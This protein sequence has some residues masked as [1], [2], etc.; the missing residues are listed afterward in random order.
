MTSSTPIIR[1][2]SGISEVVKDIIA[3]SEIL[4]K[5][6]DVKY[7]DML[8]QVSF[9]GR[10]EWEDVEVKIYIISEGCMWLVIKIGN[11]TLSGTYFN[12]RMIAESIEELFKVGI[13][14]LKISMAIERMP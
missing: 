9:L 12:A 8:S 7:Y 1:I 14:G 4:G 11:M 5:W 3:E 13:E 10:S 6:F 2:D